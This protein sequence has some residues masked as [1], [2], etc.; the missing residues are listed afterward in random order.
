[1]RLTREELGGG[2]SLKSAV[3]GLGGRSGGYGGKASSRAFRRRF[4]DV[5]VEENGGGGVN[6]ATRAPEGSVAIV[7]AVETGRG[8]RVGGG[9]PKRRRG[10]RLGDL[11]DGREDAALHW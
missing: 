10:G 3:L 5:G 1:M 4:G 7:G 2:S 8:R 9:R 11:R 6:F